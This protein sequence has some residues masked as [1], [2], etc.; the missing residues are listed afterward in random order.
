M[1]VWPLRP[2][3]LVQV[4]KTKQQKII[5]FLHIVLMIIEHINVNKSR[6]SKC[7]QKLKFL[8][9]NTNIFLSN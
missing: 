7:K 5:N 3:I 8:K 2:D 6:N 4:K 9:V 1:Q